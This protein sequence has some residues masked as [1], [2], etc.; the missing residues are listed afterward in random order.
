MPLTS[1]LLQT[2]GATAEWLRGMAMAA[3][4]HGV[5]KQYGGHL[6]SAFLHSTQLPNALTARCGPDYIPGSRRS[7]DA[8][9]GGDQRTTSPKGNVLI[10][11]NTLYPWAVGLLPYKDGFLSGPQRWGNTSCFFPRSSP[12]ASGTTTAPEWYGLQES[13][14]E[15]HALVSALTAGPIAIADGVGDTDV[16]LVMRTC[17]ADGTLL[18]P[19]RPAVA[20]DA[21][22]MRD[23]FGSGGPSGEVSATHTTLKDG[24]SQL[25]WSFILS[26]DLDEVY[27]LRANDLALPAHTSLL[28]GVAWRRAYGE[29]FRAPAPADLVR[30]AEGNPLKLTLPPR[31]AEEWGKYVL[32]RTAPLTCQSCG[33]ALLGELSK[34]ISVSAQ[35]IARIE[36]SCGASPGME[37]DVVGESGELV[38][39]VFVAPGGGVHTVNLTIGPRGTATATVG[40]PARIGL[41]HFAGSAESIVNPERGFRA[42][43]A[44][45]PA[46]K[47]LDVCATFNL[48]LAQ[49]YCYMW[50]FCTSSPCA[51]LSVAY[52]KEL[53]EGFARAR[54]AGVKLLLR[55][56][57]ENSSVTP[58]NGPSTYEEI[59]LH[60]RQLAPVVRRNAD[61][62]HTIAAGFVGAYGEWHSSAHRLEAN[63]SGLAMLVDAELDW[64]LPADRSLIIRT[65]MLTRHTAQLTRRQEYSFRS[66]CQATRSLNT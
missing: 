42:E 43:F 27:E 64:F 11:R 59:F 20:I 66:I 47:N 40:G 50:Q 34:L 63:R 37:V 39:L 31:Q 61:V 25:C 8:C 38:Q 9:H 62:L 4:R 49:A 65:P 5:S 2:H 24:S 15:L 33:W 57:Y 54:R 28:E 60:M 13:Y 36:S 1:Y 44:D 19:D 56:A 16:T 35:R 23:A 58:M 30:F 12:A 45:F 53:D 14:P 7:A 3:A 17:R 52:L 26:T 51:P 29:P 41:L 48:T 22:L 6:S 32:W 10:G 21:V 46:L 18:K 55:F